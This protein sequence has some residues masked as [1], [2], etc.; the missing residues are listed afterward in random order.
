MQVQELASG[1]LYL[2]DIQ[3]IAEADSAPVQ[4]RS[5]LSLLLRTGY[6]RWKYSSTTNR[7]SPPTHA[8]VSFVQLTRFA[9]QQLYGPRRLLRS[10]LAISRVPVNPN[11]V[12]LLRGAKVQATPLLAWRGGDYF[13]TAVRLRNITRQALTL[14]PREL[15]GHWYAATFQHARLWPA[16]D[17]ADT[18]SVYLISAQPFADALRGLY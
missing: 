7:H 2:L 14:D 18:T 3:A 16:G 15:R 5:D 10:T 9:A 1:Q 17:E 6:Q 12:P 4:I 8:T 11:P 13:V